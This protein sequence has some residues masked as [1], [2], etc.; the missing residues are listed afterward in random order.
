MTLFARGFWPRAPGAGPRIIGHRGARGA[1]PENTLGAFALAA[2]LGAPAVE[3]D[4]RTCA[5]GELVVFHDPTLERLTGGRDSRAVAALPWSELSRVPLPA[6]ERVPLLAEVLAALRPRAVGVNVEMKHDV[7]ERSAV[8][9]ATASLL[10]AWDPRQPILVSSFDPR[11]LLALAHHAPRTLRALLV[12]RSS[13]HLAMLEAAGPSSRPSPRPIRVAAVHLDRSIAT[14]SR[15]ATLHA[16]GLWVS[17]WT[18]NE[19]AE[20][21]R[22]AAMG[23]DGIITDVPGEL[24]GM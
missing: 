7:P 13:Y 16:R 22:F 15:V 3:L 12:H 20:A 4:V 17:V 1:A 5:S 21:E 11:M 10:R 18:V 9:R 2:R 24:R 6:G 19:R 23:V 14:P 8:V